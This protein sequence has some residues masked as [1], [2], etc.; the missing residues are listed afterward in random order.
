MSWSYRLVRHTDRVGTLDSY[1]YAIHEVYYDHNGKVWSYNKNPVKL[2]VYDHECEKHQME[3]GALLAYDVAQVLHDI[4]K[5]PMIPKETIP[6]PGAIAPQNWE[7]PNVRDQSTASASP[8]E[9]KDGVAALQGMASGPQRG[10]GVVE[11][12]GPPPP[13]AQQP[14]PHVKKPA[15]KGRNMSF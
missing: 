14:Q 5:W 11:S 13:K 4:Q 10:G 9:D 3:P 7:A 1:V 2:H 8:F 6:E 15:K 12:G